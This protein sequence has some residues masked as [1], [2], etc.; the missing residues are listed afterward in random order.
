MPVEPLERTTPTERPDPTVGDGDHER[1]AHI[2][3]KHELTRALVD[4]T[5]VTALC[6][7]KWV[8]H[9]DPE[10]YPVCQTCAELLARLRAG[11]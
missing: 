6:G 7:K 4:G 11:G 5:E 2:V 8:P 1:M 9:R 3:P 10:R